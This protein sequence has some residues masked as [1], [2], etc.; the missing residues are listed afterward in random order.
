M[1]VA[2]PAG[3]AAEQRAGGD[4]SMVVG[5]AGDVSRG[6]ASLLEDVDARKTDIVVVY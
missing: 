3:Q 5:H 6:V 4:R 1:A 2:D